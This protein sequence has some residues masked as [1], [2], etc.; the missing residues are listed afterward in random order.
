MSD[1]SIENHTRERTFVGAVIALAALVF[2]RYM[3]VTCTQYASNRTF[4]ADVGVFN[5]L[6]S[7]PLHGHWLR[8]P[9]APD[10]PGNYF[11]IHFQPYL[12]LLT[13]FY[14]IYDHALT[15]LTAQTFSLAA[16]GV[17]FALAVRRLTGSR[18][19]ALGMQFLYHTN[20]FILSMHLAN[21]PES[22]AIPW[23]FIAF[24]GLLTD[25]R[26]LVYT[27]TILALMV[28][29][30]F[31]FFL[32]IFWLSQLAWPSQRRTAITAAA[33]CLGW[34]LL[35]TAVSR[36]C[37]AQWFIDNGMTPVSRFQS[38]GSTGGDIVW[39]L[40]T[41]PLDVLGRIFRS[42]LL[43]LL[44]STGFLCLLDWRGAWAGVAAAAVFLI[45][46]DFI[47]RNLDYY[48]S[49]AAIPLLMMSAA[50][51]AALVMDRVPSRQLASRIGLTA[52]VMIG[53]YMY[54]QPT[55]TDGYP[56]APFPITDHHRLVPDVM[57][58]LPPDASVAAQYDLFPRVPN[59]RDL[60][61]M[62]EQFLDR[63]EYVVLDAQG[64]A[65]DLT[66]EERIRVS[67]RLS[68]AEWALIEPTPLD[69]YIILRRASSK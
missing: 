25:R 7:G 59:R 32:L 8:T 26:W 33:I 66:G 40:V 48:Y 47:I 58:L 69:G 49:Y 23:I 21:H 62:R 29:G 28:K 44:A 53:V 13:P 60:F 57:K 14:A 9:L 27:S 52:L 10:A 24:L 50:R 4:L 45:T 11:G 55:R 38:M 34:G 63:V 56:H 68:S 61:P 6:C 51:G 5:V 36:F 22:L 20:H 37:G 65:P 18:L 1:L 54:R 16:A 12:L 67:D 19:A 30:D 31:A 3:W 41:H 42:P 64:R 43:A 46:D 35:A 39:Y 2:A 17:P 15:L